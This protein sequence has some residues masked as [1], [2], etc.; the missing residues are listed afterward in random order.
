MSRENSNIDNLKFGKELCPPAFIKSISNLRTFPVILGTFLIWLQLCLAW[1]IALKSNL[2]FIPISLLIIV[3]CHQAMALWIHEGCHRLFENQKI[4]DLWTD[5]FFATPLGTTVSQYRSHHMTHHAYLGS[6]KDEDKWEFSFNL[7]GKNL[8]L[9]ILKSL[10]GIYGFKTMSK[11]VNKKAMQKIQLL[12]ILMSA[13]WNLSLLWLCILCGRWYLYFLLWLIPLFTITQCLIIIRATAEHQPNDY[14]QNNSDD[15]SHIGVVRTTL[16]NWFNK[17]I[18][19]QVNFN[20]HV[21]HHM[22]LNIPF[23]N[24]PK[25]HKHLNEKGYYKSNPELL[26]KD[27]IHKLQELSKPNICK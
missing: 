6:A 8:V 25:L 20:Y 23:Y 2:A 22:F 14:S 13:F 16:P 11:Y 3:S 7:R 18:F 4:N 27:P 5:F 21:E 12:R 17:W 9:V 24:L 10:S 1:Y 19:Y 26:Q 15:T